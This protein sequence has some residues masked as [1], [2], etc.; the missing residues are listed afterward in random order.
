MVTTDST[1]A[2]QLATFSRRRSWSQLSMMFIGGFAALHGIA[3]IT[4]HVLER[5][6]HLALP[7]P[8]AIALYFVGSGVFAWGG[9]RFE[10]SDLPR[11]LAITLLSGS[12]FVVAALLAGIRP[13]MSTSK[14]ADLMRSKAG[15]KPTLGSMLVDQSDAELLVGTPADGPT[16]VASLP[17][18]SSTAMW[19]GPN[20]PSGEPSV[21][22]VNIRQSASKASR[23]R[24]EPVK[25]PVKRIP[26]I[27]DG[28]VA[29]RQVTDRGELISIQVARLDW[30]VTL[31]ARAAFTEDPLPTL[32]RLG[33]QC[34]E[35]LGRQEPLHAA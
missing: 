13:L 34:I 9:A 23:V 28:C 22:T 14:L 25:P 10:S 21:L 33:G 7:M 12:L 26:D 2:E 18:R 32:L 3:S 35:R 19:T 29:V 15:S 6:E 8:T 5:D 30:V 20:A 11:W 1:F 27:G 24:N 16:P 31:N 17:R 4:S